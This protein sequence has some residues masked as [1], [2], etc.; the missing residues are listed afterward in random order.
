MKHLV[1]AAPDQ[2]YTVIVINRVFCSSLYILS[3]DAKSEL[4]TP[5]PSRGQVPVWKAP[6]EPPTTP[7]RSSN[8]RILLLRRG[9][10]GQRTEVMRRQIK[11]R[12]II[13]LTIEQPPSKKC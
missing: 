11:G 6:P 12:T 10:E 7:K 2:A 5:P 1:A 8:P 9:R 4:S 3:N 13:P